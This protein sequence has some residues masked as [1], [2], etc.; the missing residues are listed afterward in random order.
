[1]KK[2]FD[3]FVIAFGLFAMFVGASNIIFPFY[4]GASEE[5]FLVSS[6]AFILSAV[7]LPILSFLSVAKAGGN[8]DNISEVISSSFAKKLTVVILLIIG[9][10]LAIPRTAA[11]TYELSVLPFL[12]GD[13]YILRILSSLVFFIFCIYFVISPKKVVDR[14]GKY[15]T[16]IIVIFTLILIFLSLINKNTSAN[17]ELLNG[18]AQQGNNA[19]VDSSFNKTFLNSFSM[20]Y[21]TMDA[22]AAIVFSGTIYTTLIIKGYRKN[23]IKNS[24]RIITLIAA[25][26]LII[27]YLGLMNIGYMHRANLH[28]IESATEL[29]TLAVRLVAGNYGNTILAIVILFACTTTAIGLIVTASTYFHQLFKEKFSYTQVVLSISVISFIMSIIGVDGIIKIAGPILEIIYPIVVVLVLLNLLGQRFRK[30]SIYLNSII[31]TVPFSILNILNS[32]NINNNIDRI[33][34]LLPLGEVGLSYLLPFLLYLFVV[35]IKQRMK[36]KVNV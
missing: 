26:A 14:I 2:K 34:K 9:P 27:L 21:Q 11:T 6:L 1:M 13:N 7:G 35:Y 25:L 8:A 19:M 23:K 4:V 10:L 30:R 15:L 3:V 33:L 24:L 28:T 36:N 16:P 20:G 12:N 31:I 29:T 22:L 18:V 5:N 17:Q 32:Y